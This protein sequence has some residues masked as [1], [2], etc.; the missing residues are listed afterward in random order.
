MVYRNQHNYAQKCMLKS[1]LY[2]YLYFTQRILAYNNGVPRIHNSWYSVESNG[3][4]IW[5]LKY[6][7]TKCGWYICLA[8]IQ[9]SRMCE[10]Y[11]Y[12]EQ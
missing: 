4:N 2:I 7:Y 9:P 12:T 5:V 1:N 3:N 11:D 10:E 6:Q 8:T